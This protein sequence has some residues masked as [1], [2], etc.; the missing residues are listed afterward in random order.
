MAELLVYITDMNNEKILFKLLKG[1]QSQQ[2]AEMIFD[3]YIEVTEHIEMKIGSKIVSCQPVKGEI[4]GE[5]G[6]KGIISY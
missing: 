3:A 6:Y 2:E 1:I 4:I 5:E